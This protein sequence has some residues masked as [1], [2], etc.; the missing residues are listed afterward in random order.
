M[1]KE[2]KVEYVD[3][4]KTDYKVIARIFCADKTKEKEEER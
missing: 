2:L 4:I 3:D 1:S